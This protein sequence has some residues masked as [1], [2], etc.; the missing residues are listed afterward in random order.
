MGAFVSLTRSRS[1]STKPGSVPI[2]KTSMP[3]WRRVT[4]LEVLPAPLAPWRRTEGGW[5]IMEGVVAV[6]VAVVVSML[7]SV[8]GFVG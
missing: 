4:M 6:V 5:R 8:F 3:A 2:T 1:E 7:L